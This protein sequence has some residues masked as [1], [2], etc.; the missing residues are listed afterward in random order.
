MI[1]S[2]KRVHLLDT[3][4]CDIPDVALLPGR[5]QVVKDFPEHITT[6][7]TAVGSIASVSSITV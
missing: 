4:N 2:R 7:F 3:D 6:R 1:E 5:P